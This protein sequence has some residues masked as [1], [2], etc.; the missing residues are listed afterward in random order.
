MKIL[1]VNIA[2]SDLIAGL[3]LAAI[4]IPEVMGYSKI[5]GTPVVTGLY[6]MI[7]PALAFALLGSS[8]G[9]VVGADSAT[10]AIVASALATAVPLSSA[11]YVTATS[12][13][14]LL[15]GAM[16]LAARLLRLGFLA[17]FLSRT[18]LVGFLTG[19][20]F[21]VMW[22]QL[23][24]MLKVDKVHMMGLAQ[25][26]HLGGLADQINLPS[27]AIAGL[28]VVFT[29]SLHVLLPKFP[30]ALVA[31]VG[32]ILVSAHFD[33]MARGV[34]TVGLMPGGLPHFV[35]P[36]LSTVPVSVLLSTAFSCVVVILSQS[37]ATSSAYAFLHRD[38]FDEDKDL[39]GLGVANVAAAASGTFVV[40]GSPTR[41]S[42]VDAAGGRS[43]LAQVTAACAAVAVLLFLTKPLSYLPEPALAAV[44]FVIGFRLV[45]ARGLIDI[46]K[47]SKMEFWLA[48]FTCSTVIALGV[49]EGILLSL[50]LSILYHVRRSYRPKTAVLVKTADGHWVPRSGEAHPHDIPDVLV[51]WFGADLFY[52]NINHF[53]SEILDVLKQRQTHGGERVRLLIIDAGAITGIDYSASKRLAGLEAELSAQNVGM[54]WAHVS[55]GLHSDMRRHQVSKDAALYETLR[56]VLA[57]ETKEGSR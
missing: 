15:S 40:N 47:Q 11:G 51:F 57:R 20:G 31:L 55:L 32:S 5:I 21:Q 42:I 17:N 2:L 18:V 24:A 45:D 9:L 36:V 56:E 6:T 23:P 1:K 19:V 34:I 4:G 49:E 35:W 3:T 8:R 30:G 28:V 43:Q 46:F 37:A 12:L 33:F 7:F 14:A 16:L 53:V 39:V 25:L 26:A 48:T 50:L 27:V 54:A 29:M 10:A 44:V 41:T 38:T 13:I 22:S 52:A